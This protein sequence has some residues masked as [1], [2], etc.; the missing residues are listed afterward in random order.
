MLL[1]NKR[2]ICGDTSVLNS[3]TQTQKVWKAFR[4][5]KNKG[6]SNSINHFKVNGTLITNKKTSG[7]SNSYKSIKKINR[8]I[9]F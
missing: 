9:F 3:K 4:K 1:D 6:G 7:R 2:R 5:I 8:K